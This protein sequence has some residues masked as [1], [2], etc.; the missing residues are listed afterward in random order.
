MA[1]NY[2]SWN[3]SVQAIIEEFGRAKISEQVFSPLQ[4]ILSNCALNK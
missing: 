2:V 4:L 1:Q 3:L